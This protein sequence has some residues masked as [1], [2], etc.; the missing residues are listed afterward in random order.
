MHLIPL[1]LW[2]LSILNV[3][4]AY[5]L[6]HILRTM[7]RQLHHSAS[8]VFEYH[9]NILEKYSAAFW[10]WRHQQHRGWTA[11]KLASFR[12]K[13][14]LHQFLCEG[15]PAV[16]SELWAGVMAATCPT[17]FP[18]Q[19]LT[20][21]RKTPKFRGFHIGLKSRCTDQVEASLLGCAG[22]SSDCFEENFYCQKLNLLIRIFSS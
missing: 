9:C 6:F 2:T 7:T 18:P 19:L 12:G 15:S 14:D 8:N 17:P 21:Q 1:N 16:P 5:L 13:R 20:S 3:V 22:Q 11:Q 4:F 10:G